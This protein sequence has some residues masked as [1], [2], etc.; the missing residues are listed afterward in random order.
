MRWPDYYRKKASKISVEAGKFVDQLLSGEF[1]WSRLRQAQKL[2][3][4][5]ERYGFERVNAPCSRAPRFE[6]VDVHGVER[7]L[8]QALE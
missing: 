4:L 7:I 8:Q 5:A 1:P 3:R 2:L 6:L